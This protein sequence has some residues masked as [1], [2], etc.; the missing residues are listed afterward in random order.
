LTKRINRVTFYIME[1]IVEQFREFLA[2]PQGAIYIADAATRRIR[3]IGPDGTIRSVVGSGGPCDATGTCGD[4]GSAGAAT[5]YVAWY[6]YRSMR[7]VYGQGRVLTL[8]KLAVLS[9]FY[10]VSGSLYAGM[11]IHALM[12][13]HSGQLMQVAYEREASIPDALEEGEA[14]A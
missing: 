2:S 1:R 8:G 3:K 7:V 12:D 4:G 5:L 6:A 9:F 14:H 13:A 10:L 11:I